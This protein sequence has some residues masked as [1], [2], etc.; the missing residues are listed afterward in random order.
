M[1]ENQKWDNTFSISDKD[2]EP[3]NFLLL[4]N[5]FDSFNKNKANNIVDEMNQLEI[6]K[7]VSEKTEGQ[8]D[9]IQELEGKLMS[10]N[11]DADIYRKESISLQNECNILKTSRDSDIN[12]AISTAEKC[13]DD[14]IDF[15]KDVNNELKSENNGLNEFLKDNI[16][17]STT[18]SQAKGV[19]GEESLLSIIQ[20]DPEFKI[21]DTHGENHK[22]DIIIEYKDKKYC[23]DSKNWNTVVPRKE[24]EKLVEDITRN[25]YDGGAI[26]SFNTGIIDWNTNSIARD[27]IH[28]TTIAGKPILYISSASQCSP[29]HITAALK[30]LYE[31]P[32]SKTESKLSEIDIAKYIKSE[33]VAI[34]KDRKLIESEKNSFGKHIKKREKELQIRSLALENLESVQ[35]ASSGEEFPSDEEESSSNVEKNDNVIKVI[36]SRA[37]AKEMRDKLK[38]RGFDVSS[39]K[40]IELKEKFNSEFSVS[41]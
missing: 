33:K 11:D 23:L 9:I 38:E 16:R 35:E 21:S 18:T 26:I 20:S 4:K 14:V 8:T 24:V 27:C 32:S 28:K 29:E 15:L 10:L 7:R 41:P 2:N 25:E 13:K 31:D 39:L 34:E 37:S 40:G 12:Q 36:K 17:D 1:T 5:Y 6:T 30:F 22:G 19:E 3:F